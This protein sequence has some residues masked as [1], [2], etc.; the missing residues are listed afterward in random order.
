M[1]V[2][3]ADEP[4]GLGAEALAEEGGGR[5]LEEAGP[6]RV[7]VALDHDEVIVA[8]VLRVQLPRVVRRHEGVVLARHEERGHDARGTHAQRGDV[9]EPVVQVG[10]KGWFFF[11]S[12][13]RGVKE[14]A[15]L[16]RGARVLEL[17]LSADGAFDHPQRDG[18]EEWHDNLPV[19]H[20]TIHQLAHL[21]EASARRGARKGAPF[22]LHAS[23]SLV[24]QPGALFAAEEDDTSTNF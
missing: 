11:V 15:W 10:E 6:R 17:R 16:R 7:V 9:L 12:F 24:T 19:L 3:F 4:L 13:S 18:R 23:F 20:H 5:V 1:R 2:G 8:R 14:K 21:Y 22:L